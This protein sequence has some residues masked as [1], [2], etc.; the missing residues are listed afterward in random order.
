MTV[1]P[2]R[3]ITTLLNPEDSGGAFLFDRNSGAIYVLPTPV[4]GMM[5]DFIVTVT[6]VAAFHKVKTSDITA[7]FLIGGIQQWIA[8]SAVSEGQVANGTTINTIQMNGST[9]GGVIGT[10]LRLVA[11]SATLWH[12]TGLVAS[13]GTMSTP[14]VAG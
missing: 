6:N 3:G 12:I 13:S 5:F 7:E 1:T 2:S 8:A 10:H 14:F 4:A 11:L 9:T